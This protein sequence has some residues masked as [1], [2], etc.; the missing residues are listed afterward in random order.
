MAPGSEGSS[1]AAWSKLQSPPPDDR[2]SSSCGHAE[3]P[4]QPV[5]LLVL[6]RLSPAE[7]GST[8]AY[9]G[10]GSGVSALIFCCT[11]VF[12]RFILLSRGPPQAVSRR[13]WKEQLLQIH[14]PQ[15]LPHRPHSVWRYSPSAHGLPP[16]QQHWLP[17]HF[18][19]LLSREMFRMLI[20]CQAKERWWD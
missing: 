10:A 17:L 3:S 2:L 7:E 14:F 15:Q 20:I 12:L 9:S 13:V 18:I 4:L 1:D 16:H 11:S 6:W 19:H 5:C 8:W